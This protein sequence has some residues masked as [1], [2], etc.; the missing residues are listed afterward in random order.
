M[1]RTYRVLYRLGVTPWR[2]SRVPAT[3]AGVVAGMTPGSAVDLGCGTGENARYLAGLG[4][5]VTG[6]DAVPAAIT[7]ARR[8]DAGGTV[9]WRTADVTDPAQVDPDHQLAGSVTLIL[10][11]GCLH[12][13]PPDQR[14]GWAA[15][16]NGIAAPDAILL[17]RAV[18]PARRPIGPRGATAAE[19]RAALGTGWQPEDQPEPTWHR[20]R[21]TRPA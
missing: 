12:G 10:D 21:R 9:T 19:L 6:V 15:T 8:A 13:I 2:T 11:N 7:A 20:Y 17:V 16:V 18:P 1:L 14:P 4:W 3:I 5:S